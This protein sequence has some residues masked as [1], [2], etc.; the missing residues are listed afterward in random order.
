M[1]QMR[2]LDVIDLIA[3]TIVEDE[4]GNQLE[5]ETSRQVFANSYGISASEFYEASNEGLKPSKAFEIYAFEYQNEQK[6]RHDGVEYTIIRTQ[7]KGDKTR[8]TGEK[9]LGN[10]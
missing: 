9:V 6:F 4:L 1:N 10:G 5:Q 2:H 3:I 7:T 8:L